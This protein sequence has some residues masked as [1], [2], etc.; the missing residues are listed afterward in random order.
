MHGAFLVFFFFYSFLSNLQ[1]FLYTAGAVRASRDVVLVCIALKCCEKFVLILFYFSFADAEDLLSVLCLNQGHRTYVIC[2]FY[3]FSFFPS[4]MS[5][6]CIFFGQ[7]VFLWTFYRTNNHMCK[8]EKKK[9]GVETKVETK[10]DN[11]N[12]KI[13]RLPAMNPRACVLERLREI[14]KI[15]EPREVGSGLPL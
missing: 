10:N 7:L 5:S 1:F 8:Y 13:I 14:P 15:K 2:K 11:S 6:L 3:L 12:K 9:N 4:C